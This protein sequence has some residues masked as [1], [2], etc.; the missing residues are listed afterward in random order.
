VAKGLG[1][2]HS[3]DVIHGDLKGVRGTTYSLTLANIPV[4]ATGNARIVDFGLATVARDINLLV[5][6]TDRRGIAAQYAAPEILR[7]NGCYSKES[8]V[9]SFGMVTIEVF[10]G[11]IPFSDLSI[12]A[13]ATSI[14]TGKRPKRPSH[15][16]LIDDLWALTQHC[17]KEEPQDRPQ[18]DEVIKPLSVFLFS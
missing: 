15:P 7:N 18:M 9:F 2:I 8:D 5:S 13:A 10:T 16:S 1:Y 17:W 6:N 11:K 12:A 3:C 4:D 14:N